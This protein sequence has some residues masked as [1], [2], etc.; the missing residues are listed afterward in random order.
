MIKK[1]TKNIKLSHFA[2]QIHV[3]WRLL[4]SLLLQFQGISFVFEHLG[5]VSLVEVSRQ[6]VGAERDTIRNNSSSKDTPQIENSSC[7]W[8][9]GTCIHGQ[10]WRS[11]C[12]QQNQ[13]ASQ[14]DEQSISRGSFKRLDYYFAPFCG[15]SHSKN[16]DGDQNKEKHSAR[17]AVVSDSKSFEQVFSKDESIWV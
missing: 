10:K 12:C 6:E 1:Q 17:V 15:C 4:F 7:L 8:V 16:A 11:L 9:L 5:R 3:A 14:E 13:I 2:N